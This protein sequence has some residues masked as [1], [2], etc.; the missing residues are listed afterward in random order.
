[1]RILASLIIMTI[2][3]FF[4]TKDE[5]SQP[6]LKPDTEYCNSRYLFCASYPNSLLPHQLVPDNN[7][8]IILRS[9]DEKVVVTLAGS[10]GVLNRT[11][12]DLYNDFIKEWMTDNEDG[13]IIYKIIEKDHYKISF[14]D[15]ENQ[16]YQQLF[17]Q[18]NKY[19]IYQIVVPKDMSNRIDQIKEHLNISFNI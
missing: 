9:E 10:R 1:M 14:I 11:T 18:G 15:G 19:V 6:N 5:T 2:L 17:N 16:Y 3:P 4:V 7:D 12:W 8:G 13:K